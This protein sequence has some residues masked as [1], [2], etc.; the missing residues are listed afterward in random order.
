MTKPRVEHGD[1]LQIEERIADLETI[2]RGQ[3]SVIDVV[4]RTRYTFHHSLVPQSIYQKLLM[5]LRD[6]RTF[7]VRIRIRLAGGSVV[8]AEV[9]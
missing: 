8:A 6:P 3:I 9:A 5:I 1:Y 7:I 4:D 2:G